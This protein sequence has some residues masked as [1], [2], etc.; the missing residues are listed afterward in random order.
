[1]SI[2]EFAKD[3]L[4]SFFVIFLCTIIG[5]VV[6]LYILGVDS[7]PSHDIVASFVL[8]VFTS[9][10]GFVLYSPEELKR[11]ELFIRHVI[12]LLAIIVISLAMATYM[13]WILWSHP[14]TVIRF[15]GLIMGIYIAVM[16]IIFY[17]S[18][19][20]VDKM[21]EKL[22]ERYKSNL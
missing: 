21:N 14:I 2:K 15:A 5:M 19:I 3:V 22:K 7:V 4:D 12:H 9:L 10:A 20:L 13:R 18:K 6:Y 11:P 16:S 1:M 17:Q 8:A